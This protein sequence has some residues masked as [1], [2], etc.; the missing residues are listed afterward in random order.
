MDCGAVVRW[1]LLGVSLSLGVT[2]LVVWAQPPL[3]RLTIPVEAVPL[4]S[5]RAL[6]HS[7]ASA[8]RLTR[9]D[10][11]PQVYILD[12]AD[13]AEQE[14][15]LGRIAA[16]V[17]QLDSPFDPPTGRATPPL[18][19]RPAY[20]GHDYPASALVRFFNAARGAGQTLTA[21]ESDLAQL[22]QRHQLLDRSSEGKWQAT[23]PEP[24]LLSLAQGPPVS[25]RWAVL[26]HELSHAEFFIN[27]AYRN[28]CLAFWHTLPENHRRLARE[29]LARQGYRPD[30]EE[31]LVNEL[32]AYLWEPLTL[33]FLEACLRKTGAS[34]VEWQERFLHGIDQAHP[35]ITDFFT[36]ADQRA[37]QQAKQGRRFTKTTAPL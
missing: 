32:Q 26:R 19:T 7:T 3:A 31:L 13:P 11:H 24:V 30:D 17:E 8:T 5:A 10:R 16:F 2:A 14:R 37:P 29:A 33:G 1:G 20:D 18:R 12:F 28:Y 4:V 36:D 22:L 23:S 34:L 6:A 15:T 9:W 25:S 27:S 21:E 35:P